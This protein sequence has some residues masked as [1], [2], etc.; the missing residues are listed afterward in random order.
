V[1]GLTARGAKV[2]MG[3]RSKDKALAA[4]HEIQEQLPSA[5]IHFLDLD[6]SNFQ[7]VIAAAKKIREDEPALHGLI[8]TAGIMG[9]PYSLTVDGYEA[10]WQVNSHCLGYEFS[11]RT[12]E[13]S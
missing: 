6:L 8:N 9:V 2:Y 10:Q 3:A 13:S 1:I 5:N 7:S 12:L 11:C 4:I